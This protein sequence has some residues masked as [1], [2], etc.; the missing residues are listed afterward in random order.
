VPT[1][2]KLTEYMRKTGFENPVG[3]P[4]FEYAFNVKMWEYTGQNP[5]LQSGMM[6]YMEG[7]RKGA[8]R[9]LDIFPIESF[10]KGISSKKDNVLFVDI[11]GNQGHDLKLLKERH[12][13]LQ[14]RL[15]LQDLPEVINR[16]KGPLEGIKV[17]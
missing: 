9:W 11:R 3:K 14:G 7:R 2:A 17:M 10:L 1:I 13:D 8:V 6:D 16:L 5:V 15:I 12:A 4:S